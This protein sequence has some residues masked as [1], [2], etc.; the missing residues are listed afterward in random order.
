MYSLSKRHDKQSE[1]IPGELL[2][3]QEHSSGSYLPLEYE[4]DTYTYLWL[5]PFTSKHNSQQLANSW[6]TGSFSKFDLVALQHI[7]VVSGPTSG[8]SA[9]QQH[10]STKH[11]LS[12]R[13]TRVIGTG[14]DRQALKHGSEEVTHSFTVI[15]PLLEIVLY[16]R[17]E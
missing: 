1:S 15:R 12:W 11:F 8:G 3:S 5:S 10:D 7:R 14:S 4:Q 17:H 9:I 16:P 6:P 2:R 13:P